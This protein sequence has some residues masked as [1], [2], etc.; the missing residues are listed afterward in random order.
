VVNGD[1]GRGSGWGTA[2]VDQWSELVRQGEA[3]KEKETATS[4]EWKDSPTS[5]SLG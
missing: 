2:D 3:G 1:S 5:W 4:V